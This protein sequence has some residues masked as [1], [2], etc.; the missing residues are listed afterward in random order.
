MICFDRE[1]PESARILM[2]KGAEVILTP[3]ACEMEDNRIC[4]FKTRAMENMVG[5]ALT[6]YAS[7]QENDHS[8]AFDGISFNGCFRFFFFVLCTRKVLDRV[9]EP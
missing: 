5:V 9:A 1:F 7:P 8:C 6:N 3:N 2:L 4:Q